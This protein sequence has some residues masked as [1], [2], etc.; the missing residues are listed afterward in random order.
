MR[1]QTI[2]I[3][4]AEAALDLPMEAPR[5]A[6]LLAHQ[7]AASGADRR[8]AG[9]LAARG[10]ATLRLDLSA[11]PTGGGADPAA[12]VAR[13]AQEMA[14]R[15]LA[16]GLIAGHGLGGTAAAAAAH[17]IG[18]A[19]A[20]ALINAFHDGA[21]VMGPGAPAGLDGPSVDQALRALRRPLLILHAPRDATAAIDNATALFLAARHPKSFLS[22]DDADHVLSDPRHA[23][24]AAEMI[25][26]WAGR[27]LPPPPARPD[28]PPAAEGPVLVAEA[29]PDR[30]AQHV[31]A[32]PD[33]AFMADEP[34]SLGGGGRGA[35]PYQLVAA[36]LG[37]CTSMTIRMYARRKG[38]PL[39]H[40]EVE[41]RHDRIH[42]GDCAD[43]PEGAGKLDRFRRRIALHG[44][45][46]AAQRARLMEIA[47]RCPVHRTLT[48]RI[49][50]ETEQAPPPA[51]EG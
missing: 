14:A 13:A 37:A 27:R 5:G 29:A 47:D 41:L 12:L 51:D 23:D 3:D 10:L 26:A 40:V 1:T 35:T 15:G 25:A 2:R 46:D 36:G 8:I 6:A 7:F 31:F 11:P 32:A 18:S 50:I 39:T 24:D 42:A 9:A 4:A 33:A 45:L 21:A 44:P 20:L 43:C 48:G 28:E 17:R 49:A 16:P 22:L 38:W 19:R 30:F 34:P